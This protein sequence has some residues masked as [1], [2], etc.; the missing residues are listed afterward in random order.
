MR[1]FAQKINAD[2][3]RLTFLPD[4]NLSIPT[5]VGSLIVSNQNVVQ[6]SW[7][8]SV[9]AVQ[10]YTFLTIPFIFRYHLSRTFFVDA[11]GSYSIFLKDKSKALLSNINANLPVLKTA[12]L[13]KNSLSLN[14]GLGIQF[15]TQNGLRL[16]MGPDLELGLVDLNRADQIVSKHFSAG[17]RASFYL[18]RY[19]PL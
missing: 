19:K 10:N 17:L 8:G 1:H 16:E 12:G 7:N 4:G 13:Q 14:F 3:Q 18:S 11:G 5:S 9:Y 2:R 15:I 6:P